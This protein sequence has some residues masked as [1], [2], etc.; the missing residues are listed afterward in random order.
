MANV[1]AWAA[2]GAKQPLTAYEL[3]LGPLGAEEVEV[4]VEHCGLCHSD[5]SVMDDEW[6]NA[7]RRA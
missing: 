3:D 4:T 7:R 5:L 1:R 2:Q 6:G